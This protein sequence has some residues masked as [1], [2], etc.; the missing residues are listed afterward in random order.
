MLRAILSN[1]WRQHPTKMEL[2]GHLPPITKT[3][4]VRRTTHAGHFWRSKD[5][6]TSDILL[7]TPLHGQ[8]KAGRPARTYIYDSSV[9]I[10]DVAWKTSRERWTIGTGCERGLRRSVLAAWHDDDDDIYNR[11]LF[12][13]FSFCSYKP[14]N[15]YIYIYIWK[16]REREIR[17]FISIS[18]YSHLSAYFNIYLSPSF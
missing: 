2:C 17:L 16:E 3:I 10:K 14:A 11:R 15:L 7:W 6:L 9:P 5:E 13:S 12:I 8:A 1:P 4:K 18:D